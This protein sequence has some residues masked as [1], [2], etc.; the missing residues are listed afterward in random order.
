M[1]KAGDEMFVYFVTDFNRPSPVRVETRPFRPSCLL[2][3]EPY[4]RVSP[5][6][7]CCV[8]AYAGVSVCV[9]CGMWECTA[10]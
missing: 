10:L 6:S 7:A 5:S 9:L 4:V 2:L 3:L 8:H 1:T